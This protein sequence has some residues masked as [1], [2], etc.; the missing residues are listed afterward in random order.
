V[1]NFGIPKDFPKL[2]YRRVM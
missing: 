2:N 1:A